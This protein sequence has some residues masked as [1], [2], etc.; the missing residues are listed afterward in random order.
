MSWLVRATSILDAMLRLIPE[1]MPEAVACV[2]MLGAL[3][4]IGYLTPATSTVGGI[5]VASVSEVGWGLWKHLVACVY[6]GGSL[7]LFVS[8]VRERSAVREANRVE[9][10]ERRILAQLRIDELKN[11]R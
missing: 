5:S 8:I 3:C 6:A 10:E 4:V 9:A 7:I 2:N 11:E 1:Y